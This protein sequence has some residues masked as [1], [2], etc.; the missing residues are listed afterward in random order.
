MHAASIVDI[1]NNIDMSFRVTGF[2]NPIQ[3]SLI[4][5]FRITT[6]ILYQDT[7][8]VID[9]DETQMAV[10]DFASLANAQIS[11]IDE[12]GEDPLAGMVQEMNDMQ[13][14]FFLPV[15]LNK[16]C[17]VKLGFPPQYSID[18]V[19]TLETLNAFGQFQQYTFAKGN[20]RI[21]NS[22]SAL[23]LQGVCRTYIENNQQA[24]IRIRSLRQP[25]Y[26]KT[27]ESFRV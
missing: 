25:N 3:A 9:Q 12:T 19:H 11:V 20:L 2:K 7:Y 18:D 10:S 17:K 4:S 13:L 15:P 14:D 6:A 22:E 16:G 1:G 21:L 27:T 5:G 24:T 23:I 26:E 8:Y